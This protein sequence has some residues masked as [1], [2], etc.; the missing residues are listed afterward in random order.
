MLD[1]SLFGGFMPA[2]KVKIDLPFYLNLENRVRVS[3]DKVCTESLVPE[4]SG[5][6]IQITF[7]SRQASLIDKSGWPHEQ[8]TVTITVKTATPLSGDS[9]STFAIRNCLEV[10]NRVIMSYQATTGELSNSGY[11]LP[12]GTSDM[13]LFADI[14]LMEGT[15]VIDGRGIVLINIP[16]KE[17]R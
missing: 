14:T 7:S 8:T 9:V 12:L 17:I 6:N 13:Q 4:L 1:G 11:I 10:L 2:V 5:E 16:C 3:Y 15:F